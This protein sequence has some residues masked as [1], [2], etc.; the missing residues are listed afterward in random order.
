[1]LDFN[2]YDLALILQQHQNTEQDIKKLWIMGW[3]AVLIFCKAE[4][5]LYNKF[6]K[7][8]Y[9]GVGFVIIVVQE[10]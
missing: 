6:K 2:E 5:P 8:L 3:F 1:M 10:D 9:T 7:N 4:I